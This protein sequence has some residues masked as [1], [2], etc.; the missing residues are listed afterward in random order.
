MEKLTKVAAV[1]G[2]MGSLAFGAGSAYA[3]PS[4]V[5]GGF[6]TDDWSGGTVDQVSPITGWTVVQSSDSRFVQGVRNTADTTESY[7]PYGNQFIILCAEDCEGGTIGYVEQTISG[8]TVGHQYTLSFAHSPEDPDEH[9]LVKV[10]ITG[11]GTLSQTFDAYSNQS[12][13]YWADWETQTWT[14]T[15]NA[16]TLTFRFEGA[17]VPNSDANWESG[18]DNIT[19]ADASVASIPTL[20]EWGMIVLASLLGLGT[21]YTLRRQRS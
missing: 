6:E 21:I 7:T 8:F 3:A 20:S 10:T 11:G 2:V 4:F 13:H 5:N 17:F 16:S 18:I 1:L 14:F 9:D 19:L 12:G 15:A